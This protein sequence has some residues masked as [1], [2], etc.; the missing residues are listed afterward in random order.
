VLCFSPPSSSS[1]RSFLVL[2]IPFYD[3]SD[4]F[5]LLPF[6]VFNSPFYSKGLEQNRGDRYRR[7][8]GIMYPRGSKDSKIRLDLDII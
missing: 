7:G 8:K 1:F 3:E 4:P 6:L 5:L 2:T